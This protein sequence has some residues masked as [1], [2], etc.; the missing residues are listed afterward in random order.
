M[1]RLLFLLLCASCRP[2]LQPD[3]VMQK[4]FIEQELV[5]NMQGE[6]VN[7]VTWWEQFQDPLL[8]ELIEKS[9][10]QNLDLK[11]AR[12]RI[13]QS[14]AEFGVEFSKLLPKLDGE[15]SFIRRR[16]SQTEGL[17]PFLG[18][19]FE[20]FYRAGFD[21][22]WEVDIFGKN[23]DYAQAAGLEVIAEAER[24]RHVNLSITSEV[25][26]NY[27]L[28]R[29]L[30]ERIRITEN[31]IVSSTELVK[32]TKTRFQT[33]LISELD[34]HTAEALLETRYADLAELK[35]RLQETI[36]AV[37]VLLGEMPD[38]LLHTFDQP[39]PYEIQEAKIPVGL[40][41]ELLCRRGDVREAEFLMKASGATVRASR[42]ELFPTLS[43]EGI[44]RYSTSFFTLWPNAGSKSWVFN[45]SL[46]LPIFHGGAILSHIA[47]QTSKQHQT[48][49]KY[50]KAVLDAVQ[51]VE[52]TLISYFQEH[53]RADA[54]SKQTTHYREAKELANSLYVAGLVDFLYLFEVEKN[55]YDSH[56]ALSE[57]MELLRAKLVAIYKALGG[58]WEC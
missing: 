31:H 37:A 48:V 43:L 45:P 26:I 19:T 52:S 50:E 29:N 34:V 28:I 20:N 55:L 56:I 54:L 6:D 11:I 16:N 18:G 35:S 10:A 15:L 17:S 2:C 4:E 58:G 47:V 39:R 46:I 5:E 51:E 1:K 53:V 25:A 32:T 24:L 38:Q 57:S 21:A 3:L 9:I 14:R 27:F 42:K 7:L 22:F 8:T 40:P 12:E 44:Y 49:L 23:W 36:Y 13:C 41:S 30:Q 33:G